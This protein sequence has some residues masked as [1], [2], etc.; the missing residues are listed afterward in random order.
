VLRAGRA[1][2]SA[3]DQ[4]LFKDPAYRECVLRAL[5]QTNTSAPVF[6]L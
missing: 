1:A 2:L 6:G 4:V 3:P 5:A